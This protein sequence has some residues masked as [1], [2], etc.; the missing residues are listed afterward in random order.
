MSDSAYVILDILNLFVLVQYTCCLSIMSYASEGKLDD[1]LMQHNLLVR[2]AP[3]CFRVRE[4]RVTLR[5]WWSSLEIAAYGDQN[6]CLSVWTRER[7]QTDLPLLSASQPHL[8]LLLPTSATTTPARVAPRIMFTDCTLVRV[9]NK[10]T[11]HTDLQSKWRKLKYQPA[12]G[13]I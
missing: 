11:N 3:G 8:I 10:Q 5:F 1:D 9:H 7:E 13:S 2:S 12:P 4:W 6:H